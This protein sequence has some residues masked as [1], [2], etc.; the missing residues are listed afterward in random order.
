M[1]AMT[2]LIAPSTF[3]VCPDHEDYDAVRTAWNLAVDQR[4]ALVALPQS[5]LDVVAAVRCARDRG[6]K[7]TAQGTGH[8]A[9]ALGSLEDTLLIRTHN[10]RGVEIDAERRIARVEAGAQWQDVVPAA[11]QHGLACLHGSAPDVGV[12]GYTLGGGT[13]FFGPK[14]GTAASRVV[15]VDLVTA[16][17]ELI[18]ASAS[19]NAELFDALRGGGGSFGIV[20]AM[21]FELF[22]PGPVIAGHL[23]FGLDRATAVFAAW[24]A[25]TE[26]LTDDVMTYARLV[27]VPD[28]PGVP[29]PLRGGQFTVIEA[30]ILGDNDNVLAPMRALGPAMDTFGPKSLPEMMGL[31]MDPPE[32]VPGSG[33]GF[34]IS[35]IPAAS[36]AQSFGPSLL[37]LQ[38]GYLGGRL[39]ELGGPYQ[40]FSVGIAATPGMKGAVVADCQALRAALADVA[41]GRETPNFSEHRTA[42]EAFWGPERLASL[43]AV[44]RAIDPD[45]VVVANH[46][47]A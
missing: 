24:A 15:S 44:K 1:L 29:E 31:H 19:E 3:L 42:P 5:D 34:Q 20:T 26:T 21:E 36:I 25:W 47:I 32:P 6:L 46:P 27:R 30:T 18:R 45:G 43:R 38:I 16:E 7:V 28:M 41:T 2:S 9:P 11:A 10:M 12:V 8:G 14:H 40:V 13:S 33:D 17:G 39:A 37:G 35:A 4:P 22:E 23:W